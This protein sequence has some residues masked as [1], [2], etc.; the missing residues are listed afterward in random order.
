M[1]LFLHL[2]SWTSCMLYKPSSSS[3][4][5][6]FP[7][8]YDGA[9]ESGRLLKLRSWDLSIL[10][11]H[12]LIWLVVETNPSEKYARQIGSFPQVGV[13]QKMKPP[14]SWCWFRIHWCFWRVLALWAHH[15][16][17]PAISSISDWWNKSGEHQLRSVVYPI[18]YEK[19]HSSWQILHIISYGTLSDICYDVFFTFQVVIA[20][21]N[22]S[23][24]DGPPKNGDNGYL[25]RLCQINGSF[26]MDSMD[27]YQ[28]YG[29]TVMYQ[30][31]RIWIQSNISHDSAWLLISDPSWWLNQ[32]IWKIC[33][34]KWVH[35]PQ[36]GMN[37]N[38]NIWNHHPGSRCPPSL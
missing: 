20:G 1:N 19:K 28:G 11:M 12:N 24:D 7:V 33:S 29:I 13:K 14:V 8:Q 22:S 35:L 15:L 10:F 6:R 4:H 38:K 16:F 17:I 36:I 9:L 26:V 5:Q 18:S 25:G 3:K 21:F 30:T 34:S 32:P 31:P 23:L 2:W 27:T 37:I